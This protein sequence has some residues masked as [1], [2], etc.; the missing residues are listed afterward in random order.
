MTD[1][2]SIDPIEAFIWLLGG[3]GPDETERSARIA[4]RIHVALGSDDIH[5]LDRACREALKN[6]QRKVMG[7]ERR[8]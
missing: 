7:T 6:Y 4:K 1:D 8:E 2:P 5:V 3:L